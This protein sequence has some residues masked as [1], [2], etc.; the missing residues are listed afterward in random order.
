MTKLNDEL[1]RL[2]LEIVERAQGEC[3]FEL[4]VD[5]FKAVSQ[6]AL[7]LMRKK[8]PKNDEEDVPKRPTFGQLQ[9]RISL[10]VEN[11]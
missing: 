5:A 3:P 4:K 6:Y 8:P 10:A 1:D 7:G 9:K 11:D 2:G